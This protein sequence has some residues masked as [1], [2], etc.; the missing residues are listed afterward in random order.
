MMDRDLTWGDGH[1]IPCTMLDHN[2]NYVFNKGIIVII[3][4]E[5]SNPTVKTQYKMDERHQQ[6]FHQ[7]RDMYGK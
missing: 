3:C 5:L 2:I 1:T 7:K 6:I 4:K